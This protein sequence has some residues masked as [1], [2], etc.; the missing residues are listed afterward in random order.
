[1]RGLGFA[2]PPK[3]NSPQK[4]LHF[5]NIEQKKMS[6]C[7]ILATKRIPLQSETK[8]GTDSHSAR[9]PHIV[10]QSQNTNKTTTNNKNL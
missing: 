6:F 3:Q 9:Y 8:E 7:C 1:M 5:T 4:N 2:H 10:F